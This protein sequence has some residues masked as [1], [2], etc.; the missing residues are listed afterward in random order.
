MDVADDAPAILCGMVGSRTGWVEAAYLSVPTRLDDLATHAT[1]V[2]NAGARFISC[3]VS[4]SAA[5]R[6]T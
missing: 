6:R 2:P 1:P 5:T 3:L 4:R